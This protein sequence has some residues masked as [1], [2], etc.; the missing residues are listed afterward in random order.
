MACVLREP[1][2]LSPLTFPLCLPPPPRFFLWL[3][4]QGH[5]S[6]DISLVTFLQQYCGLCGGVNPYA[7][8]AGTASASAAS[9]AHG[10]GGAAA[11]VPRAASAKRTTWTYPDNHNSWNYFDTD[12]LPHGLGIYA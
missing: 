8:V 9:A 6:G 12:S 4:H 2:S 11:A 1:P 5:A 7:P 3:T 10:R